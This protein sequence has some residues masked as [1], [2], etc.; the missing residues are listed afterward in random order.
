[1]TVEVSGAFRDPDRDVLT[2]GATSS[3]PGVAS[4]SVSGSTVTVTPV[5]EGTST[6]TVT[7][8][9]AGGSNTAAT[10]TFRV[11]VSPPRT[12]RRWRWARWRRCGSESTRGR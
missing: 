5:S 2:Y 8:T 11:T 9:D 6:V 10:Q 4:V 3:S 1:M 7:A 12:V